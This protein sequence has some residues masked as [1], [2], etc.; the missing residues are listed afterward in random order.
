MLV[1]AGVG[2][3]SGVGFLGIALVMSG[4]FCFAHVV[5]WAQ[6]FWSNPVDEAF[7]AKKIEKHLYKTTAPSAAEDPPT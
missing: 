2:L 4:F 1:A 7:T 3:A 5:M 6:D